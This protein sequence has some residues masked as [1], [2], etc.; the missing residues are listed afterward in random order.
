MSLIKNPKSS[1]S[2]LS[3][4]PLIINAAILSLS[5]VISRILG[6]L[7]RIFLSN[8]IGAELLGLLQLILPIYMLFVSLSSGGIQIAMSRF[9]AENCVYKNSPT[10]YKSQ[11]KQILI[12]GIILTLITSLLCSF[13][14]FFSSGIISIHY[15]HDERTFALLRTLSLA[16]PLTSLHSC[17]TGYYLGCKNTVIPSA[18]QIS[19]QLVKLA[20][21]LFFYKLPCGFPA[22]LA[23]I[24]SE[25]IGSGILFLS[26]KKDLAFKA[27]NL[28]AKVE[29]AKKRLGKE[30]KQLFTISYILTANKVSLTI[31]HSIEA[32]LIPAMLVRYGLRNQ[33]A[34]IVYGTLAGMALPVVSF[35]CAL[36]GSIS[37]AVMPEL[38]EANVSGKNKY[39]RKTTLRLAV[40]TLQI[41]I[42]CTGAFLI[43]GD[44]IGN[45][46][47]H[48]SL[49]STFIRSLCWLCPFMYLE[50][51]LGSVLHSLG[52]TKDAFAHNLFNS[53]IRMFCIVFF[54]PRIGI[55]GYLYGL[56]FGT[57][58]TVI[59]HSMKILSHVSTKK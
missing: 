8:I 55:S 59:M 17:I 35:P 33:E 39:T 23:I 24:S 36:I 52:L 12:S 57:F 16:V 18:M 26:I 51:I 21:L 50:I 49:C 1:A 48:E 29:Q 15:L 34:L 9:V 58:L 4:H 30:I 27:K 46:L 31:L 45:V 32:A 25:L 2:I 43:L 38:T 41:G 28:P 37:M 13:L 53:I 44:F 56:F 7:Y 22:I 20:S 10:L 11:N 14:M 47:F 42:L 40:L 54:I 3:K 19:E 5:G 6:F